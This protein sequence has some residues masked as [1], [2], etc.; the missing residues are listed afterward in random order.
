MAKVAIPIFRSRVAPVF[1]T[2]LSVLLIQIENERQTGK[3]ELHFDKL[4]PVERVSA[5]K[6]AGVTTLICGGITRA[7]DKL[8]KGS[9]ISVIRGVAGE[10]EEVLRA[11]M[12]DRLDEPQFCMPGSEKRKQGPPQHRPEGLPPVASDLDMKVDYYGQAVSIADTI[13]EEIRALLT[14]RNA[15]LLAH[16]YQPPEIQDIADLTG[17]C[18]ELC[19]KAAKTDA[20]VILFCGAPF[21]AETAAILSPD[22]KVLMPCK[23]I[24]CPMS[25]SITPEALKASLGELG[26]MPVVTYVKSPA[27]VKALSTVCCTSA[28]AVAVVNNL[29]ERELLMT[30]DRNL[31]RYVASKTS[32]NIH[33]WDGHCPAHDGL[34]E[35]DV[36]TTKAV[37]SEALFMA[38]PECPPRILAHADAVLGTSGMLNFAKHSDHHSFIVGTEV[39]LIH[40]LRQAN[41]KK[42]FYKVSDSMICENTKR[43][44]FRDILTALKTMTYEVKL[45]E[46]VRKK[47]FRTI[48]GNGQTPW[49]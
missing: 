14:E 27:S 36:L 7:L 40:A 30:P 26:D 19:L 20:D 29:P 45:P 46:T 12:S 34:S 1:D 38:H 25:D 22:K 31:A 16:N 48:T 3:T 9:G 49:R 39:G 47:A 6:R 13:A 8:L 2:C 10:V 21:M 44:T 43:T 15:I 41:P 4:S 37:H 23:D 18:L 11:F 17:E 24:A 33:Y 42:S 35:S 32:K 5:L 28:N